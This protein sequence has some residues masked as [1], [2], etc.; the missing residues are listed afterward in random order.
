M[1]GQ[2]NNLVTHNNSSGSGIPPV[3]RP[4]HLLE[5]SSLK[6]IMLSVLRGIRNGVFYGFRTRAPNSLVNTLLYGKGSSVDKFSSVFSSTL[7]HCKTLAILSFFT[8]FIRI[9]SV[10]LVGP[11]RAS[12]PIAAF[13]GGYV[14][15]H[16]KSAIQNQII[17]YLMSRVLTSLAHVA[18]KKV[19]PTE[20]P[21]VSDRSKKTNQTSLSPFGVLSGLTWAAAFWLYESHPHTLNSSLHSCLEYLLEDEGSVGAWL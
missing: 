12:L 6:E 3:P 1:K 14:A 10:K 17:L 20:N 21:D 18:H 5:A 16:K 2:M 4:V 11:T 8:R 7:D 9:F 15:F 19:I 13:I